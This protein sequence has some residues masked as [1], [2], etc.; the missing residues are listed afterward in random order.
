MTIKIFP[1]D[2]FVINHTLKM[3]KR[4]SPIF[5]QNINMLSRYLFLLFKKSITFWDNPLKLYFIKKLV[6]LSTNKR[7]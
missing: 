2:F 5:L 1:F 7:S 3:L 6:I 4:A